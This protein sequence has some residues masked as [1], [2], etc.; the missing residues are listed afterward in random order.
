MRARLG[1]AA[2]SSAPQVMARVDRARNRKHEPAR[3]ARLEEQVARLEEQ[4]ARLGEQLGGQE[5]RSS[6][7]SAEVE[8][9]DRDLDESRALNRRAG[10][11][12]VL[13]TTRLGERTRAD[14]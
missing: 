6:A 14:S 13:M 3:I 5:E 4:V 10:E 2:R 7:L 9:L 11:L 8:R 1:R 12:L